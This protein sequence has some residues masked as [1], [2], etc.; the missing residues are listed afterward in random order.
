MKQEE[1]EIKGSG[2]EGFQAAG[3]GAELVLD[4]TGQDSEPSVL[5]V[6]DS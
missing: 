2:R 3:K 1:R 5:F 4:G 6:Y